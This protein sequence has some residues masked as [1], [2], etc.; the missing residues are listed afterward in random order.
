VAGLEPATLEVL[1]GEVPTTRVGRAG[2]D[3]GDLVP[4]LVEAGIVRSKSEALR[5][6]EQR[7]LALND[8]KLEGPDGARLSPA[9][10]LHDRWAVVRR[11]R[12][13]VHLLVF[14]GV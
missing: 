13:Q 3:E 7:G 11:G 14:D 9:D 12:K 8:T 2:L 1:E 5:L 6:L 4:I 10:L